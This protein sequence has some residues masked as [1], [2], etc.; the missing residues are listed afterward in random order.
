MKFSYKWIQ[1]YFKEQLPPPKKLAD[2]LTLHSFEVEKIEK[3]GKN[4]IL[5]IDILPNRAHDCLSYV[6]VAKEVGAV[7]GIKPKFSNVKFKVDKKENIKDYLQIEIKDKNKCLRYMA[8]TMKG[9]KVGPSPKWIKDKLISSGLRPINNIVDATN[10]VMLETGQPLHAYDFDK[11]VGEKDKKI[12]I[13]QAKDNEKIITLDKKTF[14]LDKSILVI[15]DSEGPLAIAG[16]KG[17]EKA[18]IDENTKNVVLEAANFN[19]K[20][21]RLMRQKLKIVTD[22]SMRFEHQIDSNL[23]LVGMDMVSGI[24]QEIAGGK[25]I[26]GDLDFYPVKTNPK[27]IKFDKNLPLN[28]LGIEISEKEIVKIFK[29]LGFKILKK[30]ENNLIVEIPTFRQDIAIPYDLAEEIGRIYGLDK[31]PTILPLREISVPEKNDSI[32]WENEIKSFLKELSFS[33]VYNYSFIGEN[34]VNIFGYDRENELLKIKNFLSEEFKYLRPSLIPNLLKDVKNNFKYFDFIKIFELG[35]IFKKYKLNKNERFDYEQNLENDIKNRKFKITEMK[36]LSGIIAQKK[37]D[38]ESFYYLKGN[39]DSLLNK[40]GISDIWYDDYQKTT[41]QSKFT[42]WN[43]QKSAE[44]RIGNDKI[45]FL[46]EAS[47]LILKNLGI[48]G[49]ILLFNIDFEKLS[50]IASEEQEYI[51]ISQYPAAVR[52]ISILVPWNVKVV[53]VLN[54]I[55]RAGGILVR[56]VDL[57]DIY[58]GD[59]LPGGKKNFAF[60]IVYQA[61]N[62][63]LESK[64]IDRIQNKIIKELERSSGWEVRK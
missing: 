21:I 52:D 63:T 24:I 27:I 49:N 60:H 5:D 61:E 4:W 33:E 57:F 46:G 26:F 42:V 23:A 41:E 51:P 34:D 59:E 38:N 1:S 9:I 50:K 17:G 10:Y 3:I 13:R 20:T 44:I 54:K 7:L 39:I 37:E 12:I 19:S 35:T 15:A 32:F 31:V 36:M 2:V 55:N 16:I 56:D 25:I 22:A 48:S 29:A 40:L 62:R 53:D 30:E 47:P 43:W 18:A 45:G 11:I 28:L 64:E 6:G 14:Y 8:R 58:E